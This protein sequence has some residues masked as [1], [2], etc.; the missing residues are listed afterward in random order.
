MSE[1]P[2]IG[3]EERMEE[4]K[5]Y[6]KEAV[7]KAKKRKSKEDEGHFDKL[8]AGYQAE[9]RSTKAVMT[10]LRG[11]LKHREEERQKEKEVPVEEEYESFEVSEGES[12]PTTS[13]QSSVAS[14]EINN[15]H[16]IDRIESAPA[17]IGKS[18]EV[19]KPDRAYAAAKDEKTKRA[20]EKTRANLKRFGERTDK[21][22]V[23]RAAAKTANEE[24]K[25]SNERTQ[26]DVAGWAILNQKVEADRQKAK[27]SR[28]DE[29]QTDYV[30]AYK[31]Y[32]PRFTKNKSDDQIAKTRPPFFAFGKAVRELRRLHG[33]MLRAE[34]SKVGGL[35]SEARQ[36]IAE[37]GQWD[38]DVEVEKMKHAPENK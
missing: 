14:G 15:E 23:E 25:K 11:K 36:A 18:V 8:A 2:K 33:V 35:S 6:A 17:E 12:K 32:D 20:L 30:E 24:D 21:I 4:Y 13:E 37:S 3:S 27:E 29:A 1:A 31:K 19:E 26:K 16:K 5:K 28:S 38:E 7:V 22:L 9:R 10:E 34:D